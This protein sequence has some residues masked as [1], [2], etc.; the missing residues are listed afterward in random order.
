MNRYVYAL[1][2]GAA[3][4]FSGCDLL[5]IFKP[6]PVL[7]INKNEFQVAAS[8]G[9]CTVTINANYEFDVVLPEDA[10]GWIKSQISGTDVD[11][12]LL[13][14]S[15]NKGYEDRVAEVVIKLKEYDLSETVTVIQKQTDAMFVDVPDME[16]SYEAGTFTIPVSSNISYDIT[17]GCDWISQVDTKGLVTDNLLFAYEENNTVSDRVAYINFKS[18]EGTKRV[19]IRQKPHILEYSMRI[20][21][22]KA[23]FYLPSL[24]GIIH[25][26]TVLWGDESES[27]YAENIYH[28]YQ[29]AGEVCVE[30]SFKAVNEENVVTLTDLTD[31]KEIDLTGM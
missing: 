22:S 4:I 23:R 27:E 29:N 12:V 20:T 14:I 7:T 25:S 28:D 15:A 2:L 19:N 11:F 3:L 31:V 17:I 1:M 24:T 18:S 10:S 13:T 21:H 30:L 9:K 26:G 6:E 8:G 5:D 16:L